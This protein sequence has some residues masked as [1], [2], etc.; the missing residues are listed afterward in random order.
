MEL[1]IRLDAVCTLS[2]EH[3]LSDWL[4]LIHSF[5]TDSHLLR[6]FSGQSFSAASYTFR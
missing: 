2:I 5:L 3:I 4:L 6:Q 1:K